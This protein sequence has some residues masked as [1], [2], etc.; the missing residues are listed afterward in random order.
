MVDIKQTDVARDQGS[1]SSIAKAASS[2]N[3]LP[4]LAAQRLNAYSSNSAAYDIGPHNE[5]AEF[6]ESN[7]ESLAGI[8][9]EQGRTS[10]DNEQ[11]RSR[12]IASAV[13]AL[14]DFVQNEK[15]DLEFSVMEEAGISV[16]KITNRKSGE[17]IR[18]IPGDEVVDLARKLNDR[19]PLRLFS[20]SV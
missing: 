9:G 15:R 1:G 5:H 19:E 7:E 16:V 4:A 8:T 3:V 14:N 20:A 17:L 18:Q 2:G 10:S 11:L 6:N 12:S 13:T